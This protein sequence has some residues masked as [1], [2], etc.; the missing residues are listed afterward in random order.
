MV[1]YDQSKELALSIGMKDDKT[2][3]FKCALMASA[4]ATIFGNPFDV[5]KTRAIMLNKQA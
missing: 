3:H 2:T 5:L 1:S 4:I